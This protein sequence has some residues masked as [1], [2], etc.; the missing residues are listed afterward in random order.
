MVQQN[1]WNY[2]TQGMPQEVLNVLEADQVRKLMQSGQAPATLSQ[3]GMGPGGMGD[4][5]AA[6][7][8]GASAE[9]MAALVQQINT[10][11]EALRMQAQRRQSSQ[12]GIY[13]PP[14]SDV[15]QTA[16]QNTGSP[17]TDPSLIDPMMRNQY[18]SPMGAGPSL[19]MGADISKLDFYTRIANQ[20]RPSAMQQRDPVLFSQ[21]LERIKI[22]EGNQQ[23]W[24][25]QGNL[26]NAESVKSQIADI[27]ELMYGS[28][29]Y[30]SPDLMNPNMRSDYFNPMSSDI[31]PQQIL[32]YFNSQGLGQMDP[33]VAMQLQ[34]MANM[35]QRGSGGFQSQGPQ[36][37]T[38]PYLSM[39][40]A[41]W[42]DPNSDFARW[43][44]NQSVS[45]LPSGDGN[46]VVSDWLNRPKTVDQLAREFDP[47][48][49]L[50]PGSN[51]P[52]IVGGAVSGAAR[53]LGSGEEGQAVPYNPGT[54]EMGS[55]IGNV[56]SGIFGD[57]DKAV[58]QKPAIPSTTK[59]VDTIAREAAAAAAAAA[60]TPETKNGDEDWRSAFTEAYTTAATSGVV[61]LSFLT[62]LKNAE[63][64]PANI[65]SLIALLNS[66]RDEYN[67]RTISDP[68]EA[69]QSAEEIAA[70]KARTE[71][72]IGLLTEE[73]RANLAS[74]QIKTN[75]QLLTERIGVKNREL[76]RELQAGNITQQALDR[77]LRRDTMERESANYLTSIASTQGI[78]A[79][80]NQHDKDIQEIKSADSEKERQLLIELKGMDITDK[81]AERIARTLNE[82]NKLQQQK[83]DTDAQVSL[84]EQQITEEGADRL[85]RKEIAE[86]ERELEKELK[87]L[88]YLD[89]DLDRLM[90]FSLGRMAQETQLQIAALQNPMAVAAMQQLSGGVNPYLQGLQGLGFQSPTGTE[91]M[92]PGGTPTLG[93]LSQTDPESL[94]FLTA[95]LA[96]QGITPEQFGIQA[97]GVTPLAGA[98][99]MGAFASQALR[100]GPQYR[101]AGRI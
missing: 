84:G 48:A 52:G 10:S 22:L 34:N 50:H 79:A 86:K 54:T 87:E 96:Q 11:P 25:D 36:S 45:P 82:A 70:S 53:A 58:V 15:F 38:Y 20:G 35:T 24:I 37:Q 74:E 8:R 40:N 97:G 28:V 92:F 93:A 78:A 32:G 49:G 44:Q 99:T 23:Q 13:N 62:D 33:N 64:E 101:A 7:Q 43:L 27:M 51:V 30:F 72:N 6:G 3:G 14:T 26:A 55:S 56:F 42:N 94:N 1:N 4:L 98:P 81:T 61:D 90:E 31:M 88:G 69:A 95:I 16:A 2:R 41:P 18:F 73:E 83:Y 67:Y 63:A 65:Q 60:P 77:S 100:A 21:Y 91:G 9:E 66:A 59:S 71:Y 12:S 57:D 75:E 80:R 29:D 89:R 39:E 17:Y 85:Q 47:Y 19:G 76:E 5:L 46:G 68:M